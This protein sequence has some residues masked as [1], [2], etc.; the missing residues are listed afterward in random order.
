LVCLD[1]PVSLPSSGIDKASCV[2]VCVTR[3]Y[4]EKVAGNNAEDNCKLGGCVTYLACLDVPAS[5][6]SSHCHPRPT[7]PS[8]H[9]CR[10]HVRVAT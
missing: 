3:R 2:I 1:V 9:A 7:L 5:L 4:C 10:I 6:L 8:T